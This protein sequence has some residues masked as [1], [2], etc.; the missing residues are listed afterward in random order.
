M[1][2]EPTVSE[3][4]AAL[5]QSAGNAD[6]AFRRITMSLCARYERETGR[7]VP[8]QNAPEWEIQLRAATDPQFARVRRQIVEVRLLLL[9]W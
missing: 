7:S 1:T 6:Y 8:K 3:Q 4:L 2:I 9:G 5:T